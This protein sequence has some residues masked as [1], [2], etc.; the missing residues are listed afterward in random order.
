METKEDIYTE[1]EYL[2]MTRGVNIRTD[3][4]LQKAVQKLMDLVPDQETNDADMFKCHACGEKYVD[5]FSSADDS[6]ICR[7]CSG[8]E[9]CD[10]SAGNYN[11]GP[12]GSMECADCG[13]MI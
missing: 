6:S 12:G 7:W 2:L 11:T 3:T 10:H 9:D 5:D 8:E 13:Q 1:I 4:L